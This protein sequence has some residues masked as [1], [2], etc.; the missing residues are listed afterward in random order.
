ML[1]TRFSRAMFVQS[2]RTWNNDIGEN[3]T[4]A[5]L[6]ES[7]LQIAAAQ[8]VNIILPLAVE[9]RE[10]SSISLGVRVDPRGIHTPC[11]LQRF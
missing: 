2:I 3:A 6:N 7:L 10:E 11:R 4:E 9:P 8:A 5:D 1:E